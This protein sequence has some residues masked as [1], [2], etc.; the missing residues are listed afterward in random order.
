[1]KS[2]PDT[3]TRIIEAARDLYLTEGLAGLSMRGIGQAVGLSAAAVYRHF[4]GKEALLVA[5]C[6]EGFRLFSEHLFAGLRG[7]SPRDRLLETGRGYLRFALAHP[8]YYRV[9]FLD[10]TQGLGY[11]AIGVENRHRTSTS[12]LF[13]VD[14][15][16]ECIAAGL[17]RKGEPE[18]LA[19]MIWASVHGVASLRV[20]G[21]L[22]H[23][24][25]AQ[26]QAFYEEAL[27]AILRGLGP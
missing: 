23:L 25:E 2:A 3:R 21:E 4:A 12:F 1:M 7:T 5:V 27:V 17:L 11:Q 9:M 19:A 16:R 24:D 8:G 18:M 15:V 14:R 26:F 20:V 13:L 6:E 22:S 10:A